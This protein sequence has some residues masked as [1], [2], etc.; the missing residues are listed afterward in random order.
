MIESDPLTGSEDGAEALLEEKVTAE[1]MLKYAEALRATA[2]LYVA[3]ENP[4]EAKS[5][6]EQALEICRANAGQS[7]SSRSLKENLESFVRETHNL[8]RQY[9]HN[10]D[11]VQ[12]LG[13]PPNLN[14]LTKERQCDFI[15]KSFKKLALKWHPDKHE[16][17]ARKKR[18][19]RKLNDA[20]EARDELNDRA[21]CGG[22]GSVNRERAR[23]EKA[24]EEE[25]NRQN[26]A[27]G[28]GGGGHHWG[29]H[30]HQY[31]RQRRGGGPGGG[32][33]EF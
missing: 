20:A 17:D 11:Y 14:E 7:S 8:V 3:D 21:N 5:L 2:E 28:G 26:W 29:G 15:K 6:A 1:D 22:A 4:K 9:E 19:A 12:I 16:T 31:Q 24:K 23:A 13:A 25:R 33:W 10:R 27:R 18:A 30:Q 32:H